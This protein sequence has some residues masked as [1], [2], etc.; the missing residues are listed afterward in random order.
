LIHSGNTS[1]ARIPI[2]LAKLVRTGEVSP[3]SPALLFGFGGGFAFAGQVIRT[4]RSTA[5]I[6]P[7]DAPPLS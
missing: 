7:A 2:A 1:S 3:D 5:A 4:P 6:L